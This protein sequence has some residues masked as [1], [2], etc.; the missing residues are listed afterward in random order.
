MLI[1]PK[2]TRI[3]LR[4]KREIRISKEEE[5]EVE[6]VGEPEF[7]APEA[8]EEEEEATEGQTDR[9]KVAQKIKNILILDLR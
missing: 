3:K 6:V 2:I 8:T 7:S 1:R 5:V 9:D 4:I